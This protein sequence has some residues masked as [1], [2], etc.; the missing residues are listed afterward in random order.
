MTDAKDPIHRFNFSEKEYL[1]LR[2]CLKE[3]ARSSSARKATHIAALA[4]RLHR[5]WLGSVAIN[6]LQ[7][8]EL[9]RIIW[10]KHGSNVERSGKAWTEFWGRMEHGDEFYDLVNAP[11]HTASCDG[12]CDDFKAHE[13]GGE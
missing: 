7:R 9:A 6:R 13:D 10:A 11:E 8:I 1:L 4:E 5:E 3:T 2:D 12:W